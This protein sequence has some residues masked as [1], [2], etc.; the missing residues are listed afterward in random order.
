MDDSYSL[1]ALEVLTES[2]DVFQGKYA[3]VSPL[4]IALLTAEV[5]GLVSNK[6]YPSGTCGP[7]NPLV[8]HRLFQL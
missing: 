6:R 4:P 3:D 8:L 7:V 2:L 5:A 1:P